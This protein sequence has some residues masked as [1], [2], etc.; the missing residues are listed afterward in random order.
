M[1]SEYKINRFT[2]CSSNATFE[3][4]SGVQY[5]SNDI[6]STQYN[7]YEDSIYVYKTLK[8]LM[9]L[10]NA[11]IK[12][13]INIESIDLF[14]NEEIQNVK[15]NHQ[16]DTRFWGR[17]KALVKFNDITFSMVPHW[18]PFPK[19]SDEKDFK[20][21]AK[22]II[23]R[24]LGIPDNIPKKDFVSNRIPIIFESPSSG[25]LLH[26]V[27]GHLLECDFF[28]HSPFKNYLGKKIGNENLNIFDNGTLGYHCISQYDDEG[29][30]LK[31][32]LLI[33][34]G[35]LKQPITDKMYSKMLNMELTGNGWR[36]FPDGKV[37]PRMTTIYAQEGN[38]SLDD[39]KRIY[40]EAVLVKSL[41]GGQVDI[42]SGDF[43]LYT[44]EAYVL[45]KGVITNYIYPT[46]IYGNAIDTL[47]NIVEIGNDLKFTRMICGK[48]GQM[49]P[50]GIGGPSLLIKELKI[51]R[52]HYGK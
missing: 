51:G 14:I 46:V 10:I 24:C 45:H 17:V 12:K 31:N 3:S 43:T 21:F 35:Y 6:N 49:M 23:N 15:V 4:R 39:I 1:I 30:E 13:H 22:E 2:K 44:E 11:E 8:E 25:V 38:K 9:E 40:E 50:V 27:F 28:I 16:I 26:E 18:H 47:H 20:D 19:Y 36:E 32:S 42:N 48:Q 37:M 41:H 33:E 29:N 7:N 34:K 52:N 5:F